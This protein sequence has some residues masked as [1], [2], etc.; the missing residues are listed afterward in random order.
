MR[1]LLDSQLAIWW[2]ITP[3]RLPAAIHDWIGQAG[4]GVFVS[5]ASLWEMAIKIGTGKLDID[6]QGFMGHMEEDGFRWL[7][8]ENAH[9]LHLRHLPQH[10]DHKDPFDRLLAAQSL[11][12]PMILLTTDTRLARYG[13]TVRVI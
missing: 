7:G 12:E 11:S 5:R 8:I 4:D 6:L 13:S 9:L 10:D 2:Q 3:E 1:L